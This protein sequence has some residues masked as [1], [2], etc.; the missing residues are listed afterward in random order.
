MPYCSSSKFC[1]VLPHQYLTFIFC[2]CLVAVTFS[3]STTLYFP[4]VLAEKFL[5]SN[6]FEFWVVLASCIKFSFEI[7][8]WHFIIY[9]SFL[10]VYAFTCTLHV[11]A[12]KYVILEEFFLKLKWELKFVSVSTQFTHFYTFYMDVCNLSPLPLHCLQNSFLALF[13]FGISPWLCIYAFYKPHYN[14][15]DLLEAAQT[16]SLMGVQWQ[17]GNPSGQQSCVTLLIRWLAL[18]T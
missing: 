12:W 5:G 18:C 9:S 14:T 6:L 13:Q 4:R 3:I 7:C 15:L 2:W 17:K 1:L 10:C 16:L 8:I 11:C